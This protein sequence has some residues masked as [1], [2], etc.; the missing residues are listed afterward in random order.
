[1]SHPLKFRFRLNLG[2]HFDN[3]SA[4]FD[5]EVE[6]ADISISQNL[7]EEEISCCGLIVNES[8]SLGDV[9]FGQ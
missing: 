1:M 3:G 4:V 9:W 8:W 2:R 5:V 7:M 6:D